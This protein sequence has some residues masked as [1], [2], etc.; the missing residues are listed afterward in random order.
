MNP[1][2]ITDRCRQLL[3]MCLDEVIAKDRAADLAQRLDVLTKA[4]R[5]LETVTPRQSF[6]RHLHDKE[7]PETHA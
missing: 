7:E 6:V 3:E 4:T 1:D 5:F 2:S